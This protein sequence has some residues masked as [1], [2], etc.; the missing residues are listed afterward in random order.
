[1]IVLE[2]AYAFSTITG[3]AVV[4]INNQPYYC[5]TNTEIAYADC[6]DE[7]K[8]CVVGAAFTVN[9]PSDSSA[10]YSYSDVHTPSLAL[11]GITTSLITRVR[12][13]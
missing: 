13:Q 10:L 4:R 5:G 8:T 7:K 6:A 12:L 2:P 1:M 11:E 9:N 3:A